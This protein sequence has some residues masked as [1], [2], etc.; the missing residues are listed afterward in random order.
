M[1]EGQHD[2]LIR[3]TDRQPR[4]VRCVCVCVCLSGEVVQCEAGAVK[5]C[6]VLLGT[7]LCWDGASV[8]QER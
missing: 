7:V 8:R 6:V 1:S 5:Y 3:R 2:Q 4:G